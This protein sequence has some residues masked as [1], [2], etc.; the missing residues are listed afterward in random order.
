[1]YTLVVDLDVS[2]CRYNFVTAKVIHRIYTTAEITFLTKL[3]QKR[4][5]HARMHILTPCVILVICVTLQNGARFYLKKVHV[6]L[7]MC[8]PYKKVIRKINKLFIACIGLFLTF[9]LYR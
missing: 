8:I 9:S 6:N 5:A 2:Y 3:T 7:K 4:K 1:L